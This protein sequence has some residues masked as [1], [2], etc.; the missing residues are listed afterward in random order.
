MNINLPLSLKQGYG[1]IR[2][3]SY[4]FPK[5][6][7][8]E[9]RL[10]NVPA[11]FPARLKAAA[12]AAEIIDRNFSTELQKRESELERLDSMILEVQKSLHLV[13]YAAVSS[14]Y[15]GTNITGTGG[16]VSVYIGSLFRLL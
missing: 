16:L 1:Q 11:H 15:S 13:R 8:R 12:K 4:S 6:G 3:E 7:E 5:E 9:E 10:R 2:K 14:L